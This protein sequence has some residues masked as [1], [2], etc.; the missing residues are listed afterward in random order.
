MERGMLGKGKRGRGAT[1]K[2]VIRSP[3]EDV[4]GQR[5]GAMRLF[6]REESTEQR[7]A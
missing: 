3:G 7:P 5:L 4:T 1:L 2:R 6:S